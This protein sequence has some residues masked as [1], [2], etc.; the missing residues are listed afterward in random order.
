MNRVPVPPHC[1][2]V[3]LSLNDFPAQVARRQEFKDIAAMVHIALVGMWAV[4][5]TGSSAMGATPLTHTML[6]SSSPSGDG[7]RS[8]R[9]ARSPLAAFHPLGDLG[10]DTPGSRGVS[11]EERAAAAA[12]AAVTA[13]A[14]AAAWD[15]SSMAPSS[16]WRNPQAQSATCCMAGGRIRRALR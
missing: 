2:A 1:A 15:A 7:R 4:A 13:A 5:P 8:S 11:S 10:G 9:P 6:S 16:S 3:S 14:A 12:E